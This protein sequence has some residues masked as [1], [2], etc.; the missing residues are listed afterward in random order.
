M[1]SDEFQLLYKF[2]YK[3]IQN[4]MVFYLLLK[5]LTSKFDKKHFGVKFCPLKTNKNLLIYKSLV[6]LYIQKFNIL[7]SWNCCQHIPFL[8][9]RYKI[10]HSNRKCELCIDTKSKKNTEKSKK[11]TRKIRV[12]LLQTSRG[13]VHTYNKA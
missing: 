3:I 5:S 12:G 4:K 10:Q 9:F 1:N 13:Y 7:N 2:P 11:Y 8:S 6:F